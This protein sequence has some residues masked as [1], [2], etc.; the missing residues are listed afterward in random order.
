MRT[1]RATGLRGGSR[2]EEAC[3]PWSGAEPRKAALEQAN[4][5]GRPGP[6]TGPALRGRE[7]LR[8]TPR[9]AVRFEGAN[10]GVHGILVVSTDL[11]GRFRAT[12][13]WGNP[14]SCARPVGG[15]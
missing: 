9:P 8:G 15:G 5:S 12:N 11:G 7:G 14:G 13:C 2:P 10:E 4:P 1:S 6:E 3:T